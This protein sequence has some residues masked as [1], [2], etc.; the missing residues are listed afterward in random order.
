MSEEAGRGEPRRVLVVEDEVLIGIVLE[1]I[2][3]TMGHAVAG[4]AAT[5]EDA[6]QLAGM[7]GFDAAILDVNVDGVEIFD[8]ADRLRGAGTPLIF[9]T[10]SHPESLPERFRDGPVLEKPYDYAAVEQAMAKLPARFNC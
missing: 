10:G 2:L 8:L 4:N 1:D 7:G 3:Q 5:I 6:E 9:A